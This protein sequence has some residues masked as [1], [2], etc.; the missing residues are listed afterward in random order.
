MLSECVPYL[1]TYAEAKEYAA[2]VVPYKNGS[3]KAGQK[4]LGRV[5][6]YNRSIIEDRGESVVCSLYGND[7]V[8]FHSDGSITVGTGGYMTTMTGA[9]LT[10]VLGWGRIVR[11]RGR[12]YYSDNEGYLH[13]MMPSVRVYPDGKV[14]GRSIEY[15]YVGAARGGLVKRRKQYQPFLDYA[16]Q[17][18]SLTPE[19]QLDAANR[20]DYLC[21]RADEMRYNTRTMTAIRKQFFESL[22]KAL[23]I[24]DEET[25]LAELYPLLRQAV[26]SWGDK[27]YKFHSNR[28]D[29][30]ICGYEKL[31][32]SFTELLRYQFARE[33]FVRE[34][35]PLSKKPLNDANNKYLV[36]I[37]V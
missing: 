1:Y 13:L 3:D 9:F 10:D 26:I 5:R 34:E 20:V 37:N 23:T 12:I 2:G 24:N 30:A 33:L 27:P 35:L 8:E 29:V 31:R 15:K 28:T 11:N 36:A 19:F 14:E 16:K 22:E 25:R 17:V 21:I 6:R 4:P 32:K 7:L 18:L